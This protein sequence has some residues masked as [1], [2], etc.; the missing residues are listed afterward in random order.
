EGTHGELSARLA[1]GLCSDDAD[2]FAQFHSRAGSQ[3]AAITMDANTVLTFASE[4]RANFDFLDARA[5]NGASF[6]FVSFFVGAHEDFLGILRIMDVIAGMA[7]DEALGE[8]DD[9]V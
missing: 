7:S 8:L 9:F 2:G 4:H 1:D 6:E 5:V 3:I